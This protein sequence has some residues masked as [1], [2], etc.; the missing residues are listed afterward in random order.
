[1][2]HAVGK[3]IDESRPGSTTDFRK[4]IKQVVKN[5][6]LQTF[7]SKNLENFKNTMSRVVQHGLKMKFGV[8]V[9][10]KFLK[11]MVASYKSGTVIH[12][13]NVYALHEIIKMHSL[14]FFRKLPKTFPSSSENGRGKRRRRR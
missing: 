12:V 3:A 14:R 10:Q 7:A 13:L 5:G 11:K 6:V 9:N 1:M 2:E 8:H 4:H